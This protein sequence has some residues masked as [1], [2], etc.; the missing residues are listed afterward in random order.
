MFQHTCICA[1]THVY[2]H[3]PACHSSPTL[4]HGTASPDS[5]GRTEP[6]CPPHLEMPLLPPPAPAWAQDSRSQLGVPWGVC[7]W[8][9]EVRSAPEH[10]YPGRPIG[11]LTPTPSPPRP[12][13]PQAR[14]GFRSCCHLGRPHH[15]WFSSAAGLDEWRLVRAPQ[16]SPPWRARPGGARGMQG[17]P[18]GGHAGLGGGDRAAHR[19]CGQTGVGLWPCRQ[20]T[21][22]GL[23]LNDG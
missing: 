13:R 6:G 11:Q 8:W 12:H 15:I 18:G 3:T 20:Q 2:T 1:H 7:T 16:G 4:L 14:P 10:L 21:E 17:D 9:R 23:I 5:L 22:S 19:S